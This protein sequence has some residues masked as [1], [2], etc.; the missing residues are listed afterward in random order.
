MEYAVDDIDMVLVMSVNPGF[1]GQKF[2]PQMLKKIS[3][4]R[5]MVGMGID[6]QVDGGVTAENAVDII[7]AGANILVSGSSVFSAPDY[8]KAIAALR[9]GSE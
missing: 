5:E 2:I 4:A 8:A 7:G 3:R 1:S 9:G 6:V